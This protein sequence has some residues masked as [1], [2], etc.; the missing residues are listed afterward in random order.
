MESREGSLI[1]V[2][3]VATLSI[4][5]IRKMEDLVMRAYNIS[6][7]SSEMLSLLRQAAQ[8]GVDARG[9]LTLEREEAQKELHEI[10]TQADR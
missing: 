5:A 10:Q 7:A 9:M 6:G 3:D 8:V 2:I 4:D 1:S